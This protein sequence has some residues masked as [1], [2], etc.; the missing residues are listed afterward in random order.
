MGFA[1]KR[2]ALLVKLLVGALRDTEIDARSSDLDSSPP[3]LDTAKAE[4]VSSDACRQTKR[5]ID[6]GDPEGGLNAC[7]TIPALSS[8]GPDSPR[9]YGALVRDMTDTPLVKP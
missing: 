6:A 2:D 3:R 9:G 1:K 7:A 5:R 4:L 8:A